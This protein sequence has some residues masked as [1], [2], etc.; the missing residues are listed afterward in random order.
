MRR[1]VLV[2]I[3]LLAFA[4][5]AAAQ[6]N[7]PGQQSPPQP[8]TAPVSPR[9]GFIDFGVRV[10]GGSGD[11][12]LV[13]EF[14][15]LRDGVALKAL[16]YSR[17]TDAWAFDAAVDNA[18]YRD[19]RYLADYN[20][21][22]RLRATFEWTQVP[23]FHSTLTRT[24]YQEEASGVLR[25]PDTIQQNV[26]A[27][28]ATLGQLGAAGVGF[29]TRVRRQVADARVS[30]AVSPTTDLKASVTST[31]RRGDQPWGAGFGFTAADEVPLPIDQRTN[32]VNAALQW[33]DRGRLLQ[34]GYFGSFYNNDVP[35]LVW[36]SPLALSDLPGNP[37]QGRMA[38]FPSSTAHSVSAM[39]ALPLPGRSRAHAYVSIG[40]WNQD[41]P[42]VPHT[43]NTAIPSPPLSRGSAEAEAR[44]TALNLGVNSRAIRNVALSARVRVYDFDNRT[45]PFEQPQYVRADQT[46]A[47]SALGASEPFEYRRNFLDLNAVYTGLAYAS[48]RFGYSMEHD[49]RAY[50]FVEETTDH[51]LRA[52]VDTAGF[53]WLTIRAQ[54]EHSNRSGDGFDEIAFSA[55]NEQLSLRQFDI[56]D[57]V[58]DRFSTI[59]QLLP[60]DAVG[61]TA[62]AGIGRDDRPDD[63]FG[64]L[65]N[66]HRFYT[67]ALDFTPSATVGA[68]LS[69]GRESF[70]TLQRSR[71]A[72]PG[73]QFN[74]PTRDWRA[75]GDEDVDTVSAN[76]DLPNLA[77]RTGLRVS[78]DFSRGRSRYIYL[79]APNSTLAVPEQLPPVRHVLHRAQVDGVYDL[80]DRVGLG[81]SYWFDRFDVS[82]FAREPEILEP[83]G[84]PGSGLYLGYMLTPSTL[85][86]GWVRL[87]YRF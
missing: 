7:P 52:S 15:D 53:S 16:Q 87:I 48:L 32:D 23:W 70:D 76:L 26:Q 45:P 5:A 24:L 49:D 13:Q 65:D 2:L 50:R 71:Q 68:G 27:G 42:L 85:H 4:P 29:D 33:A 80:T 6:T 54:Y 66:D 41:E 35:V 34:V 84:F 9:V 22:G 17:T 60:H 31:G 38:I 40:T 86:T 39:G 19:Q 36:D 18:P 12:A 43:I 79:L 58:R 75:D 77:P 44:I 21:F 46:V 37:G 81:V 30:Y 82:D 8:V 51:V 47:A 3:G 14:R 72:N 11:P 83:L 56:S 1:T 67:V 78:Y 28:R 69:Y 55:I 63:F 59:L 64:L 57:R 74:D 61:I 20:R 62:T 73:P 10:N 25:L